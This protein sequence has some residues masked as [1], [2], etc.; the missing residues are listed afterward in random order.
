[1]LKAF[2]ERLRNLCADDRSGAGKTREQEIA[3][4]TEHLR[5]LAHEFG[6]LKIQKIA[7]NDFRSI[8]GEDLNEGTEHFIEL[9][10]QIGRVSKITIPGKFGLIPQVKH[11]ESVHSTGVRK[12]LEFA[13]ATPLEYLTRWLDAN[14]IFSDDVH[15]ETIVEWADGS[16]SFGITQPQYHGHPASLREIE[17]FFTASHWTRIH[18]PS[19]PGGH[20]IFYHYGYSTL[21]VDALPRNC[22]IHEGNLL[23]F[24]VILCRPDQ[25]LE[26][27]LTLYP[28]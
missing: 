26:E 16:L 4:Q 22:Y 23:P 24:D 28:E 19:E 17:A 25:E 1:M 8:V 18:D 6:I 14:E 5:A 15:L 2:Y 21:A 3:D 20:I 10:P 27:F 12:A 7:Y 11:H 9:E 13:A